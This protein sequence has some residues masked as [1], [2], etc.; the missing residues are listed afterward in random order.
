LVQESRLRFPNEHQPGIP[1][2]IPLNQ[3]FARLLGY[4][5]AEG[6]IVSTAGRPNSHVL[7]FSYAPHEDE[8]THETIALL[9]KIFGVP[10]QVV[11]RETT[12]AVACGKTSVA[13]L[14]QALCGRHAGDKRVPWQLFEAPPEIVHAFLDAYV[15]GDGHIYANGKR[16]VTTTSTAM[17]FGVAW[18]ALR[19]GYVPGIYDAHP[20]GQTQILGRTVNRSP[21][22]YNV[23]WYQDSEIE[24]RVVET[25]DF[26]LIPVKAISADEF[27]GDVY[28]M[29][30][31][32]EHNYLANLLL[33]SNCQNW[34]IS[35]ALRDDTA[36]RPP[37]RVTPEQLIEI[38][39]AQK[40]RV[41]ASSYN[42]P[43]ITSEWA[44]EI[45]Q[46]ATAAGFLCAYVSN[47]NATRQVLEYIKPYVSAYKIDLK[48]MR[49][50]VYRTLGAPL[51]HILEGIRM[52][53]AMGFW[54]EIVTLVVPGLNDS[55]E[56][57][58]DAAQFLAG[59]SPDIPWHV[60][61]FHQDYK[62]LDKAST[63]VRDLLRACEIGRQAGLHYVYAGN[64][65]G[66]VGEWENTYCPHCG[67]VLIERYGYLIS[68]YHLSGAGACPRCGTKIPGIWHTRPQ[69]VRLGEPAQ[70][71]TRRPRS[72]R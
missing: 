19:A 25:P 31:A 67:A 12:L 23:V 8:W 49:D 53:H 32:E 61:A 60:T 68:G 47:G 59:L 41:F 27:Q 66:H 34:D 43:L 64:L 38:G 40:A 42:E 56:E 4:Y 37:S 55:E 30:V 16:S 2:Q 62:M 15:D 28:N 26:Y 22:Q 54:L 39:K 52:V 21:H 70:W 65:P 72:V 35:Q 71:W 51:E 58:R 6:S 7:N 5:C 3:D 44:V 36:G 10:S 63:S 33:V 48:S 69:D 18:L 1:E 50:K 17:A 11:H 20:N 24:R 9:D 57:L 14:F 45:F 13:L 29:Q 46:Q